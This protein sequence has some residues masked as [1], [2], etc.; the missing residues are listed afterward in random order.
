ML[1]YPGRSGWFL[2]KKESQTFLA[3][4]TIPD[5]IFNVGKLFFLR[6][7]FFLSI[8][9]NEAEAEAEAEAVNCKVKLN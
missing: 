8:E 4:E 9:S 7:L 5:W 2:S 1:S 3:C 6:K